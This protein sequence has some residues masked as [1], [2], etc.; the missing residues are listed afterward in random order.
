MGDFSVGTLPKHNVVSGFLVWYGTSLKQCTR[1][2]C[3]GFSKKINLREVTANTALY[4]LRMIRHFM[5]IRHRI[6]TCHLSLPQPSNYSHTNGR[7]EGGFGTSYSPCFGLYP[8]SQPV[9]VLSSERPL[10]GLCRTWVLG[11]L[12]DFNLHPTPFMMRQVRTRARDVLP[13]PPLLSS[14]LD[15]VIL[16]RVRSVRGP[17]RPGAHSLRSVGSGCLYAVSRP[18]LSSD[19]T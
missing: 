13:H 9:P 12:Q 3:T 1:T 7:H 4:V 17:H 5:V 19:A 10:C 15:P 6:H 11:K 14:T 18:G 2:T 16:V 8:L